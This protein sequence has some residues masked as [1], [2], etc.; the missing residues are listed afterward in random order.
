M[1]G[2]RKK[3]PYK[4]PTHCSDCDEQLLD[5]NSLKYLGRTNKRCKP[6]NSKNLDKYNKKR[7]KAL[8]ESKIW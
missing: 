7:A 6:C 1:I 5:N 4:K 8:K 3:K 2:L